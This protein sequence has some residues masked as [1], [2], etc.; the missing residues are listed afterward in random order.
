V[1]LLHSEPGKAW[2]VVGL[3]AEVHLSVRALQEGFARDVQMPPMSYLRRL[4][5]RRARDE[6]QASDPNQT[7]VRAVAIRL[8]MVHP[9]RFAATYKATFGESPSE[10]LAGPRPDRLTKGESRPECRLSVDEARSGWQEL[11]TSCE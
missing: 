3:A 5:L 6:L 2:T 4:R 9:G 7:T 10:T 8:G 1:E 11:P